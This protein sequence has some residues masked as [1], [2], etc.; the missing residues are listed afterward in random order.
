MDPNFRYKGKI[1]SSTIV[2]SVL[3]AFKDML[4]SGELKPGSR[5]PSE[6]EL[7]EHFGVGKSSIREVIKML[8]A[9][10]VVESR[11]GRGTY[12]CSAPKEDTLNPLIFQMILQ[13]GTRTEL[14]QFRQIYETAYT[15]MALETMNDEDREAIRAVLH[16]AEDPDQN[17]DLITPQHDADFHR[18][19]LRS[20][21]NPYIIRT[22]E[23]L[24]E[25][26]EE[27]LRNATSQRNVQEIEGRT[28]HEE[29]FE[30][31]CRKDKRGLKAAL[32]KSFEVYAQRYIY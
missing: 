13:Q 9:A 22:G 19:V 1:R 4:L 6:N 30:A 7:V 15:F 12:V 8:D 25:L 32:D 18:A 27:T 10:G 26:F 5:L 14:L 23:I 21:H 29:I 31:M 3:Q 20:T 28:Y 11:Q 16:P 24:I 17:T 2:K